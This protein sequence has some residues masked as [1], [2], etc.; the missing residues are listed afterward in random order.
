MNTSAGVMAEAFRRA[1]ED[2]AALL[3][4]LA[5]ATLLVSVIILL[6]ALMVRLARRILQVVRIDEAAQGFLEKYG[7]PVKPS[8]IVE[9]LIEL[10]VAILAVYAAVSV[11][12]PGYLPALDYMV[13]LLGKLVS[14]GIVLAAAIMAVSYMVE[15]MG[16]E[17]GVRGFARLLLLLISLA[18]VIDLTNLSPELKKNLTWGL[19]LGIGL[20]IGVFTAWY[21]FGEQPRRGAGEAYA[22]RG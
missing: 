9:A 12:A 2:L 13:E 19:G 10:G 6:G 20:A 15:G 14:A 5:L 3:P 21:F 7:I 8:R 1:M 4:R 22:S 18:L 16:M 11:V 17:R